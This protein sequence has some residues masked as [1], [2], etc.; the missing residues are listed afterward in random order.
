M[1]THFFTLLSLFFSFNLM[2]QNEL[3]IYISKLD[4]QISVSM[5]LQNNKSEILFEKNSKKQVPSASII[6]IPILI[7]FFQQVE[8]KKIKGSQKHRLAENERVGGSGDLQFE[9]RNSTFSYLDIATKMISVSDNTATNILI[10]ILGME[11]INERIGRWEIPNTLLQRKMMDIDAVL[12]GKQNFTS[13][14]DS[15]TLLLDLL[16]YNIL[17]KKNGKKALEILFLCE[18]GLTIPLK[19]PKNIPIAHKTGTLD[20]VR[21]DSAIVFGKNTL[22]LTIFVENFES[23]EQA[24][25]IIA[26]LAEIS[27]NN[28]GK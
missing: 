19:I 18:D 17:N 28:F 24:E 14:R 25:L 4:P 5:I 8:E 27:Y 12:K 3:E 2:A 22:I 7:T 1:K 11:D 21:G 26:D 16:N 9:A 15:N 13:A 6:K 23:M 10:D 20:Y